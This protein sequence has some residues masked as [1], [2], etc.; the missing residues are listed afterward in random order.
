M[1]AFAIAGIGLLGGGVGTRR[2]PSG[3]RLWSRAAGF[4]RLLATPSAEERFDYAARQDLFIAYIPY[5]VA[6]GVAETWAAKY[7]TAT[8]LEP[9]V[10]DWYPTSRDSSPATLYSSSGGLAGFDAAVSASISAYNASQSSSSSSGGSSF[11]SGGGSWGGGGG[12]G[13]GT[14]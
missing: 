8:G 11:S 6:L 14:W 13:G 2:T 3:R 7:R 12:G 5:A 10:P 1:P 4:E 9:P